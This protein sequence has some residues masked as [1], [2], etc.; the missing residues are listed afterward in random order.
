MK[1][2]VT[3]NE[4][5][6]VSIK[7]FRLMDKFLKKFP[8]FWNPKFRYP[9]YSSS[10]IVP[11]DSTSHHYPIFPYC[12]FNTNLIFS[13]NSPKSAN[14]YLSFIFFNLNFVCSFFLCSP[15]RWLFDCPTQLKIRNQING[16]R[17]ERYTTVS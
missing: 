13:F 5:V 6:K 10:F 1:H 8:V 17:I 4:K 16:E 9:A 12:Y 3:K 2:Y 7:R 15:S 11:H 14:F